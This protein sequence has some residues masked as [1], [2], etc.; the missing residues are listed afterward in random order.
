MEITKS[1]IDSLAIIIESQAFEGVYRIACKVAGDFA[2]V[3]GAQPKV[4][5][6]VDEAVSHGA[7]QLVVAATDSASEY[8][9]AD[10]FAKELEQMMSTDNI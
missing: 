5:R 2:K 8:F 3:F 4:Y 1:Q 6:S 10:D 9:S 7:K